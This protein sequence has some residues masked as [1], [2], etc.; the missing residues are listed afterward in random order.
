MPWASRGYRRTLDTQSHRQYFAA[1]FRESMVW[2]VIV[3]STLAMD[4]CA[5]RLLGNPE[6]P[7]RV[8]HGQ[9]FA[10]LQFHGA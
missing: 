9:A 10:G 2:P 7:T 6:F 3:P 1:T 5:T 4:A 8:E